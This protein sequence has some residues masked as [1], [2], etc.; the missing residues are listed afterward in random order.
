MAETDES[1]QDIVS[2]S[3]SKLFTS[4]TVTEQVTCIIW[5]THLSKL[6]GLKNYSNFSTRTNKEVNHR[7]WGCWCWVLQNGRKKNQ[8]CLCCLVIKVKMKLFYRALNI[9]W[10]VCL[11]VK[12][13]RNTRAPVQKTCINPDHRSSTTITRKFYSLWQISY[14]MWPNNTR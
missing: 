5:F 10:P 14:H 9:T 13:G 11:R 7:C 3:L 1:P 6:Q 4:P 8:V 12:L 2:L